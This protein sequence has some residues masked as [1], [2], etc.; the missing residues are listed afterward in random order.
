L[1]RP[2]PHKKKLQQKLLD[3][4][5]TFSKVAEYKINT[6]KSE[7]FPNTHN[8]QTEKEFRKQSHLQWSQKNRTPM[9]KFNGES[10]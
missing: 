4:L 3:I 1:Q 8:K 5:N 2:L 10:E 9:S 6:Q 7:A